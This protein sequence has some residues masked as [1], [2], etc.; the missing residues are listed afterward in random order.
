MERACG[1][2]LLHYMSWH[3]NVL[4]PSFEVGARDANPLGSPKRWSSNIFER[5]IGKRKM[6][7][8]RNSNKATEDARLT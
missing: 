6:E 1:Q 2:H 8:Q 7:K 4:M 3:N 5:G